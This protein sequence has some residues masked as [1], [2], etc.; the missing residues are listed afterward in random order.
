MTQALQR[1]GVQT[2]PAAPCTPCW[3]RS[4]QDGAEA[5]MGG[6]A[7]S[8]PSWQR[9]TGAAPAH[10]LF[11][12]PQPVPAVSPVSPP[13]KPR[14]TSQSNPSA[15]WAGPA[16]GGHGMLQTSSGP[17]PGLWEERDPNPK[18][19]MKA[20]GPRRGARFP[21]RV[22]KTSWERWMLGSRQQ[23][24]GRS[25]RRGRGGRGLSS[26]AW[27]GHA[28]PRGRERSGDSAGRHQVPGFLAG[29]PSADPESP[30]GSRFVATD[31]CHRVG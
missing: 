3:A 27:A 11:T 8:E 14:V 15:S 12:H 19:Q 30:P 21:P 2:S 31:R 28:G 20:G 10:P 4:P 22:R 24:Q 17:G 26:G 7:A 29:V 1:G 16:V 9:V 13:P 25:G 6:R 23:A 5:G 18:R